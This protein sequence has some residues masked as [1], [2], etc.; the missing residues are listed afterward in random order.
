MQHTINT[1]AEDFALQVRAHLSDLSPEAVDELTDGLAADIAERLAVGGDLEASALGSAEDY[2][3]ELRQAAWLP[4]RIE[5]GDELEQAPKPT[6]RDRWAAFVASWHAMWD[7]NTV[8]RQ[9]RDFLVAVRPVWWILRALIGGVLLFA[10]FVFNEVTLI[11]TLAMVIVSIQW[12]R[13]AWA[14]NLF[15]VWLRRL[16]NLLALVSMPLATMWVADT[17]MTAAHTS[18]DSSMP[19]P[20]E[21]IY[22]RS[23]GLSLDD[24]LSFSNVFAYDCNGDLLDGVRLFTDQGTPITTLSTKYDDA[25]TVPR[26]FDEETGEEIEFV[27]HALA[28]RGDWSAFPLQQAVLDENGELSTPQP[29]AA[30]FDRVS[31]LVGG[32]ATIAGADQPATTDGERPAAEPAPNQEAVGDE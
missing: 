6:V 32:C 8:A 23:P 25:P 17:V 5:V 12:G 31:A 18:S 19:G 1:Q 15:W 16:A 26:L 2:A 14:P 29:G 11:M 27:E 7:R 4:P 10:F 21:V 13:G 28:N 20:A 22:Q 24:G 9:L 30:P 3:A